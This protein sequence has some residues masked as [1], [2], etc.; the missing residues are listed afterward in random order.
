MMPVMNSKC[1]NNEFMMTIMKTK[2][3]I[4]KTIVAI[5]N[6]KFQKMNS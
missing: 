2:M 6:S 3:A 4:M 5:M 1:S